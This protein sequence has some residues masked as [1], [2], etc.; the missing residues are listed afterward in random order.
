[1]ALTKVPSNLD[2][3][4][5]TTQSA[6]DNS[7]N[8]ATTAYVT[9][10]IANLS[11]S[12]PAALNTLNEI[13]A[14][15]GDDANY[16]ST[17]TA[18]IAAKLPLAGGTMTGNLTVNA[19][20]DADNFKING[21][22]GSD[23]QVLTSTGSGVAWEAVAGYAD[24]DVESYLDGGTSTPILTNA[25]IGGMML[26]NGTGGQIGLNRNPYSGAYVGSSSLQ[27]FQI[28]GP[29]SG[30]DFLDFQSYNSSGTYTGSVY[31]NSGKVGIGTSSPSNILHTSGTG[32]Q[33]IQVDATDNH[34]AG[35]GLYMKV[36]NSGSLVG[37]ATVRVDNTGNIDFFNG[38][39]S[40]SQKMTIRSDGGVAIGENNNGYAGQILS[41]KAGSGDNVLY[42]ESTDSKCILSVRD[43]SSTTNVGF[44][45]IANAHVFFQDG[46]EIAR[47]STGSGD[48]YSYNG[49]GIGGAGTNLH[50]LADDCEIKMAN[51]FIH[52]DN[53]G[54][55]K[56]TIRTGYGATS[57]AAELSLDGGYISFN[58]NTNFSEK[59]RIAADGVVLVN[60]T[61]PTW[62]QS[63]FEVDSNARIGNIHLQGDGSNSMLFAGNAQIKLSSLEFRGGGTGLD[64]DV[65]VV[66]TGVGIA[67]RFKVDSPT[68]DTY[69]NDGSISSLSDIRV[70]TDINNLTDGLDIVK[71]LRPVTFKYNDDSKDDDGNG[72]L[73]AADD[74]IRYGFIAQEVEEVVPHYVET[75]TRKIN[76]EEVDDFKSLSTTRMI[77]ML[78]KA[79]Q[80]LSAKND[81]LEARIETLE[82]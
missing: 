21:G 28:N 22:Q 43:N 79:V 4:V 15:L 60:K 56:F 44:G 46:A 11:D 39:S 48:K 72:M 65:A 2:A 58:T 63:K 77:P 17:T 70:K 47:F 12:A 16:A 78:F 74:K 51:N 53:S 34:A 1:M 57:S 68:G 3:T 13:A 29:M 76:N 73:A 26:K 52:S 38:T 6:S 41:I 32:V 75:S 7:T 5:A 37:T 23:G 64:F 30:S 14:A 40:E 71:Q 50:L 66:V 31:L 61:S 54:N 33:R 10:A 36:L 59:M 9:T 80:E 24:S 18:A 19:I 42:G 8:V 49:G 35:A 67:N 81:V 62:G 69:T 20:V 25:T 55:T 82:G 27:R 45:A